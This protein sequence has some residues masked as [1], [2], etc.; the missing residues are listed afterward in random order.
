MLAW[1][2]KLFTRSPYRQAQPWETP[3]DVRM[4]LRCV[5][6]GIDPNTVQEPKDANAE[7][8]SQ[9]TDANPNGQP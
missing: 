5:I 9:C 2:K 4:K 8:P 1:I 3:P 6:A 7:L